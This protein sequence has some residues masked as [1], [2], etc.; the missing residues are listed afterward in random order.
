[1]SDD[2]AP[3]EHFKRLDALLSI[4]GKHWHAHLKD[5]ILTA[6]IVGSTG[7]LLWRAFLGTADQALLM[8][9]SGLIGSIT[10]MLTGHAMGS[11]YGGMGYGGAGYGMGTG[12]SPYGG[13]YADPSLGG[14]S[15][16]TPSPPFLAT[17]V[18]PATGST[19]SPPGAVP[20]AAPADPLTTP[21]ATGGTLP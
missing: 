4:L 6:M 7:F 5:L 8:V 10:T 1:M 12:Y 2:A 21:T 14:S 20:T 9:L 3:P 13:G 17:P 16:M 11:P 18:P 19:S 15:Y